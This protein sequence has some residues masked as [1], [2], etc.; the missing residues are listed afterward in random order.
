MNKKI[1]IF[2]IVLLI[3]IYLIKKYNESF[4][5]QI[6]KKVNLNPDKYDIQLKINPNGLQPFTIDSLVQKIPVLISTIKNKF[7]QQKNKINFKSDCNSL[8]RYIDFLK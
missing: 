3:I 4:Q 6:K 8:S 1:I 5:I 7:I 2:V